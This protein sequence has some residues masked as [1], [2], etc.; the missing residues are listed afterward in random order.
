MSIHLSHGDSMQVLVVYDINEENGGIKRLNK[1]SKIC[2]KY[3]NRVQNSVFE[4]TADISKIR[5]MEHEL[6]DVIDVEI[7]SV[8]LYKIGSHK[9]DTIIIG[10]KAKVESIQDDT[11]IF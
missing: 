8:R 2:E 4:I 3:G 5:M 6:T 1:V 11:F 9:S 7:D 10:R